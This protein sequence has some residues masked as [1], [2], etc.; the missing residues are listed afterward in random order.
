MTN[1]FNFVFSCF[2]FSVIVSLGQTIIHDD[3]Q[4]TE[5]EIQFSDPVFT[6]ANTGQGLANIP[7]IS[8]TTPILKKG[9]PQL[10]SK[11]VSLA[12]PNKAVA[13]IEIIS[14]DTEILA[15]YEIAPSKGNLKRNQSPSDIPFSYGAVYQENTL[16]PASPAEIS[17]TY[18][19]RSVNSA[20]LKFYPLQYNPV[21]KDLVKHSRIRVRLNYS[22]PNGQDFRKPNLSDNFTTVLTR[23]FANFGEEKYN[24][25]GHRESM[26]I[27]APSN[28]F[29]TLAP[30][31]LWK[32]QIGYQVKLVD[33]A[34]IG[35]DIALDQFIESEYFNNAIGYVL[36]VGD[37]QQ[38]PAF[39]TAYG[40]S[41]NH[42]AMIEG[43]DWYP[44]LFMGRFS[45]ENTTQLN[46]MVQRVIRY[47]KF[48]Q[49]NGT[50]FSEAACIGSSEG[51]GDD[52]EFDF[53]HQ[54][55][56]ANKLT[57]Y[58]YTQA[59]EFYDGSQG[60]NDADG[61]PLP[62]DLA[63]A[64]ENG[65]SLMTY[66]GHGSDY[67]LG[68]TE[69][70]NTEVNLLNNTDKY[71]VFIS[72]ACVNGNFTGT[73]CFAEE[74]TRAT[75][76]N[77]NPAG[78]INT[79]MSTINQSWNPP[80]CAQDEMV[81]ILTDQYAS[82]NPKNFACIANNGL[83]KMNDEYGDAGSEM[84]AT[85]VV[86]GDPTTMVRT[87]VPSPLVLSHNPTLP[88]GANSISISGNVEGAS[89]SVTQNGV[90]LANGTISGGS[91]VLNFNPLSSLD[92]LEI[93][94]FSFNTKPYLGGVTILPVSGPYV[95]NQSW[96]LMDLNGNGEQTALYNDTLHVLFNL[97]NIGNSASMNVTGVL[98]CSDPYITILDQ[99]AS[100]GNI[101]AGTNSGII[102]AFVIKVATYVPNNHLATLNVS[103][104]DDAGNAWNFSVQMPILAPVL[105]VSN[106]YYTELSGN[107]NQNLES[108][109]SAIVT[110]SLANL[111]GAPSPILEGILTTTSD[112]IQIVNPIASGNPINSSS[113]EDFTF[114]I[115]VNS[116]A[117]VNGFANFSFAATGG[118]YGDT[119]QF[120]IP[121]N[122][123]I[124][125][126]ETQDFS[127]YNWSFDGNEPWITTSYQPYEGNTCS[128]SGTITDSQTSIL[129]LELDVVSQDSVAFFY[130][131]SCEQDWDFLKFFLNNAQQ[132]QWTGET[133]WNR[134]AYSV[135][136]GLNT[137]KWVFQK[138]DLYSDFEDA[139]YL[140]NI[141]LPLAVVE[142]T[143][144]GISENH[145]YLGLVLAPNPATQIVQI[146]WSGF[147]ST[148]TMVR[149]YNCLGEM[150]EEKTARNTNKEKFQLIGLPSGLYQIE[151]LDNKS[152]L[153]Q[154]LIIE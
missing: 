20:C 44:E 103:L 49:E 8:Q 9:A 50:W 128:K 46:T 7:F 18:T 92:N 115:A 62:P 77:G 41:D 55:V 73:T 85:W 97:E 35:S 83:M 43:D 90:V 84:T 135:S 94:G 106:Q 60:G 109:E 114:Q 70:S 12:L 76:D 132:N 127:N 146:E 13:S 32:Q 150:V 117:P 42:Y 25:V 110:I 88:L 96:S 3:A 75:D 108:S 39:N 19:L 1:K 125:T 145:S 4:Y 53:E 134:V 81:D 118:P 119:L 64:L 68:T 72:V 100:F 148:E 16:F 111:G 149:L 22:Y 45:A 104:T 74:W 95:S 87:A 71:P 113:A 143:T 86:F 154:K 17:H 121:V 65:V 37:H 27:I 2:L 30:F 21:S 80:M 14:S 129:Q 59:H 26:L 58:T 6:Q 130:R 15:N 29:E 5:L 99:N 31:V 142:D 139:V 11:S 28:Y 24:S 102:S 153:T 133:P 36:L 136:P 67:S 107:G 124:E 57:T 147:Q 112:F 122:Q 56:I 82:F 101:D 79:I 66:T 131:T 144:A 51:P 152:R 38:I 23:H 91:V 40:Y 93:I 105:S 48:P 52:N 137:F 120:T 140:D 123:I 89:V 63:N 61:N 116:V 151:V 10:L 33:Y 126:F 54:R 98:T 78:A 138:D 69:F 141:R 34:T 47:E